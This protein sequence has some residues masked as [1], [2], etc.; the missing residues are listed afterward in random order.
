MRLS[1][2]HETDAYLIIDKPSGLITEMNPFEDSLENQVKEYLSR[3][4]RKVFIGVVHRL[5]KVTS[6]IVLFCKK[7]S[8]VKHFSTLFENRAIQKTYLAV[9]SGSLSFPSGSLANYLEKDLK[10]KKA[11]VSDTKRENSK[12]CVLFYRTI[13]ASNERSLLLV[14]PKTGRYH[15][16][17]AQLAYSGHPIIGDKLYNSPER[18][19]PG[20]ICLHAYK[21]QFRDFGRDTILEIKTKYPDK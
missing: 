15:Q 21:L 16:I 5:D 19:L 20:E 13:E 11:L 1:I 10:N 8:A 9:V 6:G 12:S 14:E 17:R 3:Q 4:K 18:Y 7:K 2:V